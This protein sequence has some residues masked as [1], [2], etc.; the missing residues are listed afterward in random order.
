MAAAVVKLIGPDMPT[1]GLHV[2]LETVSTHVEKAMAT[3]RCGWSHGRVASHAALAGTAAHRPGLSGQPACSLHP[4][5][6]PAGAALSAHSRHCARGP[7]AAGLGLEL[8]RGR[9]RGLWLRLGLE[10]GPGLGL[11]QGLGLGA[12]ARHTRRVSRRRHI[13][14]PNANPIP[15][16]IPNPAG[17]DADEGGQGPGAPAWSKESGVQLRVGRTGWGGRTAYPGYHPYARAGAALRPPTLVTTPRAGAA[18]PPTLVTTPRAGA[19]Q[20]CVRVRL[21]G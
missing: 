7:A 13:Y 21:R 4:L 3:Q 16:P 11:G 9:G 10:L 15:N 8:G 6:P 19:A 20:G 12:G 5:W 14:G 18:L 2:S 17:G 1:S